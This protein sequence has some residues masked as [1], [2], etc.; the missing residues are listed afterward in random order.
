M[1]SSKAITMFI[2]LL[3]LTSKCCSNC[4][5]STRVV[6]VKNAL[7]VGLNFERLLV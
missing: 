7:S 4:N 6:S 2:A 5:R 1:I 3:K